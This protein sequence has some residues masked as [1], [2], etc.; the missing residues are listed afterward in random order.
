MKKLIGTLATLGLVLTLGV[1]FANAP[2]ASH[3]V[4]IRIPNVL[5][6]RITDGISNARLDG[7]TVNFDFNADD[8][9]INTYLDHV[10]AVDDGADPWIGS[11]DNDPAFGDVIVFSNRAADWR[12]TVQ[13]TDTAFGL[14]NIRVTPGGTNTSGATAVGPWTLSTAATNIFTNGSRTQGWQSLGFSAADYE[15]R[16]DGTELPGDYFTAVTYTILQP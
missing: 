1:G 12:V 6:L 4:N 16:L 9:A 7:T 14:A 2:S 13:A 5:F 11:T 3:D 10:T 15:I 8:A